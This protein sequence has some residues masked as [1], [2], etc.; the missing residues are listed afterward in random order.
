MSEIGLTPYQAI[1]AGTTAAAEYLGATAAFGEVT[2]GK[3]A[4]LILL[5][6]NPLEDVANVSE[7]VGVMV[8]GR[9]Y[10]ATALTDE[11]ERLADHYAAE[12]RL[13]EQDN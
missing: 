10:P 2:V 12:R 6:A 4:D 1:A 3:R 5:E 13:T 11:L 7:R 9:W 8:R